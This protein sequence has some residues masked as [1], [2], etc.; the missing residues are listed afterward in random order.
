MYWPTIHSIAP[1]MGELSSQSPTTLK[2]PFREHIFRYT[3]PTCLTSYQLGEFKKGMTLPFRLTSSLYKS[4]NDN[5]CWYSFAPRYLPDEMGWGRTVRRD[6]DQY[7]IPTTVPFSW[8]QPDCQAFPSSSSRKGQSEDTSK[9]VDHRALFTGLACSRTQ[10][11]QSCLLTSPQPK[12][13]AV[14]T[15]TKKGVTN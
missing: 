1:P 15:T 6:T 12:C 13:G 14:G 3:D 8:T 5:T 9:D 11:P 7:I 2:C 10:V 4:R